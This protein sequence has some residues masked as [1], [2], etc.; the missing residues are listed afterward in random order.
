MRRLLIV[1]SCIGLIACQ[2]DTTKEAVPAADAVAEQTGNDEA[3][4]QPSWTH[5]KD[6]AR[7]VL[8]DQEFPNA[9][10]FALAC[11]KTGPT[12]TVSADVNK[13]AMANMAPPFALVLLGANFPATLQPGADN[14]V[15][16]SVTAPLT[17]AALAAVRDATTARISVNDQYAFVESRADPG[18]EF[19]KFAADCAALTGI[20]AAR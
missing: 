1:L 8:S 17:P 12:L 10:P 20:V 14:A 13:V 6:A 11:A 19:E 2:R 7:V 5:T 15:T 3:G 9:P 16:F 18:Q 4:F